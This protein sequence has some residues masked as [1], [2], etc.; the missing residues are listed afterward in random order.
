VRPTYLLI[1]AVIV[2]T[3]CWPFPTKPTPAPGPL[4]VVNEAG[5]LAAGYDLF[6]NTDRGRSDWLREVGEGLQAAY[7][8]GQAW[9]FIGAANAGPSDLASRK[10]TDLSGYKILQ[11]QMRGST[12]GEAVAIGIKDNSDPDDGTETRRM[13]VLT[14]SWQTYTFNISDFRTADAKRIYLLFEVVFDGGPG[15]TIFVRDVQYVP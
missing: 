4:V 3:A 14:S 6:V 12:G 13:L 7:P 10:G 15:R 1:G 2:S 11:M 9:G 8:A 5:K